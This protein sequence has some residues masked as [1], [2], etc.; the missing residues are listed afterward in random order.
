MVVGGGGFTDAARLDPGLAQDTLL[1]GEQ[2]FYKVRVGY[3]QTVSAKVFVNP[4]KRAIVAGQ[5]VAITLWNPLR[6]VMSTGPRWRVQD[7]D[8]TAL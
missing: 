6:R 3:G 8:P 2:L 1:P 5:R 4:S 7:N